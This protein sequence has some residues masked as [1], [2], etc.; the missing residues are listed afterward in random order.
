MPNLSSEKLL[1]WLHPVARAAVETVGV[2]R[3]PLCVAK[4]PSAL[5]Y[6]NWDGGADE[7][8]D[9]Q[10]DQ[11]SAR[12]RRDMSAFRSKTVSLSLK[13]S[14]FGKAVNSEA[15]CLT[16]EVLLE[17]PQPCTLVLSS[18]RESHKTRRGNEH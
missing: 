10:D 12:C 14:P 6:S 18:Q 17:H 7:D 13:R 9:M 15:R 8:D 11:G 1:R 16:V 4:D 5:R 2:A 3:R